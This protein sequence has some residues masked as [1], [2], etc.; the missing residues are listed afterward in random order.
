MNVGSANLFIRS[1][2]LVLHGGS[3]LHKVNNEFIR[4][5]VQVL[6]DFNTAID[7][8]GFV[9]LDTPLLAKRL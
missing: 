7:K 9:V 8:I 2:Q 6:Q 1:I 3:I 4:H 5:I